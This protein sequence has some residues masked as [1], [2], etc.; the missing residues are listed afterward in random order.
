MR[1]IIE[2]LKHALMITGFVF[3]MMLIIEYINVQTKGLWQNNLAESKW[4]QYFLAA[5]LGAIPG[6]LGTF[7]AVTLF[8]HRI[9]SF[10]AVVTAMI[11]T[12]GDEAFIMLAMFPQKAILLTAIIF[13]VGIIAGFITDKVISKKH[14]EIKFSNNKLPFHE[15]EKCD[16]FPKSNL[17][18]HLR[19]P[20]THRIL[21]LIIISIFLVGTVLGEIGPEQWNWIRITITLTSIIA[22]FIVVTVPEHFLEEHLWEHIAKTHIPKIFFWTFGT[23]LVVHILLQFMDINGWIANN[24][25]VVLAVALLIGIIPE[26]GPHLVFVTLFASGTIPFS[27][28]LASSIVQDGHGMLPLLAE[29]KRGFLS[30]KA[31]NLVFGAIAGIIGLLLGF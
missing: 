22:L 25:F 5:F 29:S 11:A 18:I 4:K 3:V 2:V 10:G 23:L 31:V 12:S 13:V 20:S 26:S 27:I 8:S 7:T 1:I 24:M 15:E 19:K 28:L 17:L 9:I 21:L 14:F 30:V 16:C 6:C